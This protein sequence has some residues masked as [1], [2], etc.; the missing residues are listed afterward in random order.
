MEILNCHAPLKMK[1]VRGNDQPFVRKELR[2]EHMKRTRLRNN[3]LK[4]KTEANAVA[5]K[6]QRNFC[7]YFLRKT[8]AAY[9]EKLHPSKICDNKKFWKS[10][11][12]C[13]STD[14]ITLVENNVILTD[15]QK[16][17]ETFNNF[18]S[19]AVKNLNIENYEHFS[20]DDF[21]C[22]DTENIDP[23]LRAVEKYELTGVS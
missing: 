7:V 20:F 2:K 18:F 10:S 5:Y 6:K 23:I 19:N 4:N 3:Y 9:F 22:K 11:E 12:K 21:L 14:N 1:Y 17:A 15:D 16:I 8:K 13:M